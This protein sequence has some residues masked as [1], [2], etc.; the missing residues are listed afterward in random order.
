MMRR[1]NCCGR[2]T[3]WTRMTLIGY[4]DDGDGAWLELRNCVCH[5][6]LARAVA[7]RPTDPPPRAERTKV[8]ELEW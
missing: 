7:E 1:C 6:T 4:Q 8:A 2:Y 5:A 3:E